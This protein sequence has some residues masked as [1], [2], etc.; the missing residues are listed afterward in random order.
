MAAIAVES[1]QRRGELRRRDADKV[2][3][4]CFNELQDSG[5]RF[6]HRQALFPIEPNRRLP[7]RQNGGYGFSS[8]RGLQRARELRAVRLVEKDRKDRGGV[9]EHQNAPLSSSKNALSASRPVSGRAA[10]LRRRGAKRSHKGTA[11]ST[12]R[13]SFCTASRTAS[14]L[15]TPFRLANLPASRST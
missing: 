7:S 9:D 3:A 13:N 6:L 5:L 2:D 12:R 11:S 8:F 4:G 10:I 15:V 1:S 14:V